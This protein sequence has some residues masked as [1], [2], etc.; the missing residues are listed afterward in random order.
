MCREISGSTVVRGYFSI[1]KARKSACD[2]VS[3][4]AMSITNGKRSAILVGF[5]LLICPLSTFLS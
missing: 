3:N 4:D 2:C 1:Y 5:Y